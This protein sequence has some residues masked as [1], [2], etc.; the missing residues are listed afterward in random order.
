M[1]RDH[2]HGS[3][4]MGC[5]VGSSFLP[6]AL[7]FGLATLGVTG[8]AGVVS[9]SPPAYAVEEQARTRIS[10]SGIETET[11]EQN[12]LIAVTRIA[13]FASRLDLKAAASQ[14]KLSQLQLKNAKTAV[15]IADARVMQSQGDGAWQDI[16]PSP[17]SQI[18]A[19]QFLDTNRGFAMDQTAFPPQLWRTSDG[20]QQ[21]QAEALPLAGEFASVKMH[22]I[23]GRNG[24][25]IARVPTSANFSIAKLYKTNDA[26]ATWQELARPPIM[27]EIKFASATRGWILGGADGRTLVQTVN[28]GKTWQRIAFTEGD[29]T[30]TSM[31]MPVA[32]GNQFIVPALTT[33]LVNAEAQTQTPIQTLRQFRLDARG[34]LTLLS[35]AEVMFGGQP[36][37]LLSAGSESIVLTGDVYS[38][39]TTTASTANAFSLPVIVDSTGTLAFFA[40]RDG[41]RWAVTS[42]G[43]CSSKQNCTVMQQIALIDAFGDVQTL[44]SPR[45]SAS[46]QASRLQLK[47]VAQSTNRGFDACT[48]QSTSTLQTWYNSSPYKDVNFYMGGR[49]RA[50]SQANLTSSWI[51]TAL[52]QGWNLI[53]TWVGY[54]SPSSIC[55]GCD[56]FSTS[57]TTARTQGVAE[58]NLAADAAEALGLT[59]PNMIYFNL[60]KYNTETSAEPAFIDGWSAQ[61]RARGY[62]PGMY[63][64]WTNVNSF[65]SITNPPQSIWVAR[66]SGSGGTGPSTI[67]D[68]NA[69]TGVSNTIFVNNRIWQHYGDVNQ[70]WGGITIAI[71]MNVANGP[72]VGKDI[73]QQAQS[74][75]FGALSDRVI[76][77]AAFNLGATASSGLPVTFISAT[78]STC[79][80][81]GTRA[82]LLG[83]GTCTFRASQAGNASYFAAA[84]V[85]QSFNIGI[86]SQSITFSTIPSRV[87]SPA[88]FDLNANTS[89][90]LMPS[91]ASLTTSVCTVNGDRLLTVALGT[92]T[93]RASQ[94]GNAK[95]S[96]AASVDQSFSV[97]AIS[98][99][100]TSVT[101]GDCDLDGIPNGI[102][103]SVTKSPTVRDN[104]VFNVTK[105][106]IMQTYRDFLKREATTTEINNWTTEFNAGRQN[107]ST[108]IESFL[109]SSDFGAK[110]APVAR[111]YLGAFNRVPQWTG[112]QY[113]AGQVGI[114]T[115]AQIA[116]AFVASA[117]FVTTYG[118]L[119]DTPYINRIYQNTLG[120]AP[121]STELTNALNA[122]A[123]GTNTRGGL[124]A[125]LTE[126][127]TY[128]TST[129]AEVNMIMI[130]WGMMQRRA[131]QS[132]FDYWV[133]QIDT[134]AKTTN[135]VITSFL[136]SAEYRTR[137][138]P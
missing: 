29:V 54:Q 37:R 59:K 33:Y 57:S 55:T 107:R 125:G 22:F 137:F 64:H 93:V 92:C 30:T 105:L 77:T 52:N 61:I 23:D 110:H 86:Q 14:A 43:V 40:E 68:P 2:Q 75:T 89:S 31:A 100:S 130:Y 126:G 5:F 7:L 36:A 45:A 104:D 88:T 39:Q 135:G 26:G 114:K 119:D 32:V 131:D 127:T 3:R 46:E 91:Y 81:T 95:V 66:W 50:C 120:R 35:S 9:Y 113:W 118:T 69:I 10:L 49:N 122:L 58:A 117:E 78:P 63:V 83:V 51:T 13:P 62:V 41:A 136:G 128:Q 47:R 87:L 44:D 94:A 6:R 15:A 98:A 53:P 85:D 112:Q 16:N 20:G 25:V 123:G 24:F 19:L 109:T 133:N 82:T 48:A 21:W 101:T 116:D 99:C 72:V 38:L 79:T 28:G 34:E 102:E 129:R 134:G 70:T 11:P 65:V 60:E 18:S 138:L 96:A 76:N 111:L 73:A 80:V 124:L 121:T 17:T 4:F 1:Q 12:S 84:N 8:L 27:G 106:F 71:D 90:G 132:G 56:K 97:I 67:P 74:I 42:D 108:M 115:I 103:A